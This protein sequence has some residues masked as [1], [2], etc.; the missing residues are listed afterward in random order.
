MSPLTEIIEI[1]DSDSDIE[2]IDITSRS[3]STSTSRSICEYN[4]SGRKR[5]R[6]DE[7]ENISSD[8]EEVEIR[9][10]LRELSVQV[11][12]SNLKDKQKA[13]YISPP[14]HPCPPPA[15]ASKRH[16]S[17]SA[18]RPMS[19]PARQHGLSTSR[20]SKA[21]KAQLT[22]LKEDAITPARAIKRSTYKVNGFEEDCV[23]IYRE[24]FH[25]DGDEFTVDDA[26]LLPHS[27]PLYILIRSIFTLKFDDPVIHDRHLVHVH[28]FKPP[29]SGG[30]KGELFLRNAQCQDI[31]IKQ[32]L[33]GKKLDFELIGGIRRRGRGDSEYFCEFVDQSSLSTIREPKFQD[34]FHNCDSCLSR[35]QKHRFDHP[36]I[37]N[38]TLHFGDDEYHISDFISIDSKI[39]GQPF[40]FGHIHGWRKGDGEIM[41]R[42]R[43]LRRFSEVAGEKYEGFTSNRQLV[44]TDKYEDH[45]VKLIMGK[46]YVLPDDKNTRSFHPHITFWCSERMTDPHN[47]TTRVVLQKPLRSCSTCLEREEQRHKDLQDCM[48]ACQFPAADYY[49]G[50][51]GFI[52]PGLDIFDWVSAADTEKVAC[53][54][55]HHLKRRAPALTVHYGKVSDVY[56]YTTSRD[57]P[58]GNSK[59][60]PAPGTVFLMTGGPPCQGHSRVNHANNPTAESLQNKDPRNDELWVMLAEA[61][62][63]KP[64]V[65]IIENVS[66]FKDDKGGSGR[67]EAE[68]NYGRAAMKKLSQ[69]GYSC[70]LGIIDSR[71]FGTP[72]NRLRTFILGVRVGIPLPDFPAPSHANPKTTATVFKGDKSGVIKPFYLGQRATPGTGIHPAVTIQDAI[73]DLPAFEYL[74]P[75]GIARVPRRPQIPAFNGGRNDQGN[76]TKVGF[77][78]RVPY[79]SEPTNEYQKEKRGDQPTVPDHFTSYV[80]DGAHKIIFTSAREPKPQGCDRRAL[81]SEGF[82]TLLTNSSP[83]QKGTAVIHPSQDRKF[84]IAERKRAMGWPDWHRL[85]GTPLEQ[86]KLTGNGV[87]YESVQAIYMA[88]VK[89]IILPWWIEAGRPTEG[90]FQKFVEDHQ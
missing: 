29:V 9:S 47:S 40:L 74:P 6:D 49:S 72:Q 25:H 39:R 13:S 27:P 60:F 43:R 57:S 26:I 52:L 46:V 73:S 30:R 54:T 48:K 64:F 84:T 12:A 68:E 56:N 45:P 18:N 70:R 82:S 34:R 76:G 90:V 10:Q 81:L 87:C 58:I 23:R 44:V 80:T 15:T 88:L 77:P 1:G 22:W 83:G 24:G 37:S 3:N 50:A 5:K 8:E 33:K 61:F 79:G 35:H 86:D 20:A 62:R 42:V 85:A 28:L 75:P 4:E 41:V 14:A 11:E 19:S 38:D 17:H 16:K 31:P 55:L 7:I 65:I 36:Y 51:G 69:N 32:I 89:E 59:A 71:G 2:S 21:G 53:Q 63:L 67:S 78:H 66:A